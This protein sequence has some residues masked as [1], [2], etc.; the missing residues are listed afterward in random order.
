M[1]QSLIGVGSN[2]RGRQLR[3]PTHVHWRGLTIMWL[4][5]LFSFVILSIGFQFG[6]LFSRFSSG[7]WRGAIDTVTLIS[8]SVM[9]VC[10]TFLIIR[11]DS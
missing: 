5:I 3:R 10:F 4:K 6:I 11:Q 8:I 2:E 9:F 7:T 1:R